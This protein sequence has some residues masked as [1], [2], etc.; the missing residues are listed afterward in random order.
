[1]TANAW[2]QVQHERHAAR[3]TGSRRDWPWCH[4]RRRESTFRSEPQ[5]RESVNTEPH[6][7]MRDMMYYR[8]KW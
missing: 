1:M 2:A 3:R 6:G 7:R 5:T 8:A 4:K